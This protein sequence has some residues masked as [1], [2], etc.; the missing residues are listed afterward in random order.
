[1]MGTPA[2]ARYTMSEWGEVT[3][4]P[5]TYRAIAADLDRHGSVIL[6]WIDGAGS[7]IDVALALNPLRAGPG[8]RIDARSEKLVVAALGHGA[9][10][11][12]AGGYLEP[13]YFMEKMGIRGP[14]ECPT[15]VKLA[16]L[17]SEVREILT[18]TGRLT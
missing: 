13:G 14:A 16:E 15:W 7:L 10:A 3:N 4:S 12:G 17:V 1:M 6:G 5:D 11:F 2:G 18:G 9:F 8:G